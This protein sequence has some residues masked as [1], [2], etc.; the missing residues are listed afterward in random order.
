MIAGE[1]DLFVPLETVEELGKRW[2]GAEVWKYRHG[3]ISILASVPV[4]ERTMSWIARTAL[5]LAGGSE[6]KKD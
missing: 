5:G 3:H 2:A 1:H 4:M 6:L